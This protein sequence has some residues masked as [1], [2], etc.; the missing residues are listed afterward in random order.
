MVTASMDIPRAERRLA[1]IAG[2]TATGKS[3]HA[4]RLAEA[5]EAIIINADATQLY[6]DLR[7]L[8]ARPSAEEEKAASHRLYGIIDAA[9][10]SSAADW[11]DMARREI[12]R[13]WRAR[14]LPIL[15]GG[16]GMYLKT[17]LEGIAPVP[18]IA[19]EIRTDVRALPA[20]RLAEILRR[21]DPLMAAKLRLG[22][23][24]RLARA[25]E[26]V[27]GTGR[28]LALWQ[29]ETAGGLLPDIDLSLHLVDL[30][31]EQLFA[32][33]DRRFEQMLEDG[34]LE[35]VEALAARRLSSSL[36]IMKAI[37]VP[38]LLALLAG[39]LSRTEAIYTAQRDT[40]RYAKR[41]Q[42]WFRTQT[43][44]WRASAHSSH[45]P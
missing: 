42:T 25:L 31:R 12:D 23:T 6:A 8:S 43:S 29:K 24:Q 34:A 32:R 9:A 28:S 19:E 26:V 14:K 3:A 18:P 39:K 7:I 35:E 33:C 30:P 1:V 36:P 10:A 27:R 41:Q 15:V 44:A 20:E 37:G 4:L 21:E 11:A 5:E 38:P 2:A 17:L 40:R 45:M 13:A 22:D 16:T